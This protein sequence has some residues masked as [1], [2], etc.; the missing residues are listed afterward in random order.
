[1]FC[2]FILITVQDGRMFT[3]DYLKENP[4]F[5]LMTSLADVNHF[6]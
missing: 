6:R 4:H 5:N 2:T 3:M 1:M